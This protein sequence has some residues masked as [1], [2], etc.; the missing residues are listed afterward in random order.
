MFGPRQARNG[1]QDVRRRCRR[2]LLTTCAS[3][4]SEVD[5]NE[6]SVSLRMMFAAGISDL[7]I[8]I[9]P[10]EDGSFDSPTRSSPATGRLDPGQSGMFGL[11]A[12]SADAYPRGWRHQSIGSATAK[13]N[14]AEVASA[15]IT[16]PRRGLDVAVRKIGH[17]ACP[18]ATAAT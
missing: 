11:N 9:A 15:Y 4:A 12:D 6:V 8:A 1:R 13:R 3:T 16:G 17:D 14:F 2:G 7:F 5:G 10:D 18:Q